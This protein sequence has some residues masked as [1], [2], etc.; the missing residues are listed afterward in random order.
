MPRIISG[1]AGSITLA[2]PKSG[3]RP[4]TDRVREAVF[5][6]LDARDRLDDARVLDLYAGSGALGLEAASRGAR[7][8][9]L[10]DNSRE[11][12]DVSR[13]NAD[14]VKRA[15]PATGSPSIR[16]VSQPVRAFLAGAVGGWDVVFIDPPYDLTGA[17]LV[18]DLEL[19]APRIAPDAIVMVE[20]TARDPEPAWPAGFAVDRRATYGETAIFWLSPA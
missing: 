5:S 14:K 16:I 11:A 3:T 13:R 8:V 18:E 4:T 19:L 6:A 2:V 10:V 15:A 20:R 9:T 7:E 17:E 12:A 1:F